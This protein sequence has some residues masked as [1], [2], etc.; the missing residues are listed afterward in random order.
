M[1]RKRGE[2]ERERERE[3]IIDHQ[4]LSKWKSGVV[5]VGNVLPVIPEDD[6]A[7]SHY[8]IWLNTYT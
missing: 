7:G 5:A 2:R 8:P 3:N 1:E 4:L 6:D